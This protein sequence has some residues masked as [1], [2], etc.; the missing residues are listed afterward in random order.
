MNFLSP[1]RVPSLEKN[2]TDVGAISSCSVQPL[3]KH[4]LYR[5]A[6]SQEVEGD[7]PSRVE[8]SDR[9]T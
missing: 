6:V 9:Y 5:K 4:L 3:L 7:A 8:M 1:G 2:S